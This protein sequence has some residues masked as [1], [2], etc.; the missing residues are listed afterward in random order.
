MDVLVQRLQAQPGGGVAAGT[1]GEAR[2][3]HQ[4]HPPSG[5]GLLPL[6]YHQQPLP[7]LHGL[8]ELLPV[9]FPVRIGHVVDGQQH[10]AVLRMLLFQGG[11][12]DAHLRHD[13]QGIL[14]P[15]QVEGDA[16]DAGLFPQQVLI[17]IVPILPV[18]LQKILEIRFIVDDDAGD[19]LLLQ[20]CCHRVQP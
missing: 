12:G 7:D 19:A 8:V 9:V 14:V 5:L 15:L 10:R 13:V 11:H 16:A 6:G 2:V 1:E 18:M 3:Q 4:L 20:Q 17:H